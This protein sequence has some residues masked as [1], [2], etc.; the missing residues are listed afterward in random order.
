MADQE[1]LTRSATPTWAHLVAIFFGA[2]L[3]K[4][5]PGT[6]GA[7][8]TVL[9][10][11]IIAH[12][13][14]A[15]YQL[16]VILALTALSIAIGIPA[17]TLEARGCGRKDPRHVV[18]DEVAGQLVALIAAPRTRADVARLRALPLF[19]HPQ[20]AADPPPRKTSR[21][22]RHRRRRSR[23]RR[24]WLDRLA[25]PPPPRAPA[26][27]DLD[28]VALFSRQARDSSNR[29]IHVPWLFLRG[30]TLR[31]GNL[32]LLTRGTEI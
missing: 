25:I 18:I 3:G 15:P 16:Y 17:S 1:S 27:L 31:R 24:L 28:A 19:R 12:F 30:A 20:T 21:R 5:G 13:I 22:Y 7:A 8:A 23:R 26:R 32:L 2:G 29:G 9:L 11:A 14:P 6:W 10:W 4:P